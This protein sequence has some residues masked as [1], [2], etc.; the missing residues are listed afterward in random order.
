MGGLRHWAIE[1]QRPS[2][3]TFQQLIPMSVQVE[4]VISTGLQPGGTIKIQ[5]EPF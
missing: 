1:T 4:P 5:S 3:T 2:A